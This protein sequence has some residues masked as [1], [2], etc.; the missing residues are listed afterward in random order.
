MSK[1]IKDQTVNS[2]NAVINE[3]L[4]TPEKRLDVATTICKRAFN[5]V[6][7]LTFH[8]LSEFD[9]RDEDKPRDEF[10]PSI[11]WVYDFKVEGL[12]V[13]G[14]TDQYKHN[15]ITLANYGGVDFGFH[16]FNIRYLN[17]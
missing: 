10:S 8:H 5:V 14:T 9:H 15:S 13:P 11:Y 6:G 16:S 7:D 12:V 1:E 17:I 2:F 3:K 4:D